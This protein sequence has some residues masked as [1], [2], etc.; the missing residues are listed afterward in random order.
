MCNVKSVD[1][2]LKIIFEKIGNANDNQSDPFN[3]FWFRGENCDY[4]ESS[5]VPGAFRDIVKKIYS[6]RNSKE[7]TCFGDEHGYS[8]IEQNLRADFDRKSLPYIFK[9]IENSSWNRYF[10]M[11]HYKINTRLLDWTEDAIK[12]LFFAI[13]DKPDSD[14]IV[15]I[16]N[17]FNLNGFTLR[18]ML[19]N[20]KI[21]AVI[22]PLSS[23]LDKPQDLLDEKS[24]IRL[25]EITRRYLNM[26]FK[27]KLTYYPLAIYPPFLDERMA[28]QKSCFTIFSYFNKGI[29]EAKEINCDS[30]NSWIIEKVVI[31]G[32][33]K[34]KMLEQ[35]QLIGIDDSSVYPDLD[36]LGNS[37]KRKYNDEYNNV[38]TSNFIGEHII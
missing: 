31:D 10:L 28:A 1:E 20:D 4:K 36:G 22:P 12:A 29:H 34:K 5:L 6:E 9:T 38:D 3:I 30:G 18:K 19:D 37:L 14:A 13:I 27:D 26:D 35:L 21:R 33:S 2:Y 8:Y 32:K 24:R 25:K 15:W 17:P 7:Y 23:D 16:L 11:Q